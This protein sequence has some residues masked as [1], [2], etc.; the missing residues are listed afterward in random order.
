MNRRVPL[1]PGGGSLRR[2][3]LARRQELARTAFP[4]PS[5][6]WASVP[7]TV[8]FIYNDPTH[9]AL[10]GF[11]KLF[12]TN[13]IFGVRMRGPNGASGSNEMILSAQV[14]K[15]GITDKIKGVEECMITLRPH[16][17]MIVDGAPYPTKH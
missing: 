8:N 9:D 4:E 12:D 13:A 6:P 10:T 3:P 17:Y 7:L 15:I 1:K 2:V 14:Q 16:G 5:R 11:H